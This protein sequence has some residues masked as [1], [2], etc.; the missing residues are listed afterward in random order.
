[1]LRRRKLFS[2]RVANVRRKRAH[3]PPSQSDIERVTS[4]TVFGV[5]INDQLTETDHVSYILTAYTTLLY[6]L[7]VNSL[8]RRSRSVL[9]GRVSGYCTS[10]NY[11]LLDSVVWSLYS[12]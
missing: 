11:L 5:V 4:I 6:A 9:E 12:S 2:D 10:Q 7:R 8:S 3:L 1:M